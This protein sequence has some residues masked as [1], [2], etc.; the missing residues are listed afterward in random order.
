MPRLDIEPV[1]PQ[2]DELSRSTVSLA[3]DLHITSLW[4]D[5]NV[6]GFYPE[7]RD[8]WADGLHAIDRKSGNNILVVADE[9]GQVFVNGERMDSLEI[10]EDAQTFVVYNSDVHQE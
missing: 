3:Y 6:F 8:G 9:S 7:G 10:S 4:P 2:L 5:R 1:R